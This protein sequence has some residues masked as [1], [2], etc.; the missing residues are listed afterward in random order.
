MS[1]S[2]A[3]EYVEEPYESA[4]READKLLY[5]GVSPAR[6]FGGRAEATA[7]RVP[8]DTM[9]T[10]CFSMA[11]IQSMWMRRVFFSWHLTPRKE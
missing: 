3:I 9:A 5:I 6:P 8:S 4:V 11:P 10:A 7:L 2:L 1:V